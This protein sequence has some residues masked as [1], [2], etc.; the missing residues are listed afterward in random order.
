VPRE[1]DVA[2][3][4]WGPLAAIAVCSLAFAAF[5]ARSALL[6]RPRSARVEKA[7]GSVLLSRTA[8]EFGLWAFGPVTR[9]AIR[10]EVHPDALSWA[11]LLLQLGAAVLVAGGAFGAG[12]VLLGLGAACDAADGAV[13][14]GRGMA[15]EAG[16]V[17]DA[18][19]DRWAEMAVFFGFAWYY[20]SLWPAFLLAVGACAGAVMVSYTRAKAEGYG[21]D[22]AGG[23]MQRH[24]RAV[25]LTVATVVSSAWDA[26]Q[27]PPGGGPALHGPVLAALGVIAV[28]G[29]WTGWA[30]MQATR[31]ALRER[32]RAARELRSG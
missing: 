19:V 4:R 29:N 10:L 3:A 1:L 23:L 16:E 30:R 7:G 26:W 14:R 24:E 13:A 9:A 32:E 15:S 8:M 2:V 17:L 12:A 31:R 18:A 22:A 20:R 25:W 11:S 5:A 21:I 27:P 28:L 6:G